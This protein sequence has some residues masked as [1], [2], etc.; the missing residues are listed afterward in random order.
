VGSRPKVMMMIVMMIMIKII[1]EHEYKRK[2]EGDQW[3]TKRR[4]YGRDEEY[5][6]I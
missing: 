2:P 5:L 4:G 1:M 3:G 6:S